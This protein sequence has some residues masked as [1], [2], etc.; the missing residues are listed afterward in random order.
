MH[1]SP[2]LGVL[3]F[4][5]RS[6]FFFHLFFQHLEAREARH[7]SGRGGRGSGAGTGQSGVAAG[8][9]RA[10]SADLDLNFDFGEL[11]T[12]AVLGL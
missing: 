11:D 7:G 10:S 3:C 4:I 9:P 6:F 2:F 5:H 8:K 1:I 12:S